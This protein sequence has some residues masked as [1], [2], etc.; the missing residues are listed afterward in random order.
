MLKN[1]NMVLPSVVL[2]A[3]ALLNEMSA[4]WNFWARKRHLLSCSKKKKKKRKERKKEKRKKK[5]KEKS[6]P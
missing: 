1:Y 2:V 5:R 4:T 6:T 3:V